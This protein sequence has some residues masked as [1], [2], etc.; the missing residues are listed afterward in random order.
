M[1]RHLRQAG[2]P[3]DNELA[4]FQELFWPL[5]HKRN[6][7]PTTQK[8]YLTRQ[9]AFLV[10]WRKYFKTF[11]R[12]STNID[13]RKNKNM[14]KSRCVVVMMVRHRSATIIAL[15]LLQQRKTN[16]E[17]R[18]ASLPRRSHKVVHPDLVSLLPAKQPPAPGDRR[19]RIEQCQTEIR[20]LDARVILP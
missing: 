9:S 8:K 6:Q 16:N 12:Q 1:S 2:H 19:H 3:I 11:V 18:G 20:E 10:V 7:S 14:K 15:V 13:K 17:K 4:G 5:N